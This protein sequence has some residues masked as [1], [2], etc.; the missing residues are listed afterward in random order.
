MGKTDSVVQPS[1]KK[2]DDWCAANDI[3][4]HEY[5]YWLRKIRQVACAELTITDTYQVH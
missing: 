3:S 2:V 5:Y 4:H 1:G